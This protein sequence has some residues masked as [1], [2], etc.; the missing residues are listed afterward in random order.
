MVRAA[1]GNGAEWRLEQPRTDLVRQGGMSACRNDSC[2]KRML[3]QHRP[4]SPISNGEVVREGG[5]RLF[6]GSIVSAPRPRVA[7]NLLDVT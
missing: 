5:Q 7:W 1:A 4:K 6:G 3:A 2:G